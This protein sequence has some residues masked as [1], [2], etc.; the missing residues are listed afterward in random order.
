M[1]DNINP[2]SKISVVAY[3]DACLSTRAENVVDFD[4]EQ[5]LDLVDRLVKKMS[6]FDHCVGLAANQ[7]GSNLNVFV[8]DASKNKRE[9]SKYGFS[10]V[11]NAAIVER[12]GEIK[13]R[14]GCMSVTDLTVDVTRSEKIRVE[15]QDG[16]GSEISFELE[17]F[18]ARV[19]QHEIDH[20]HGKV[21]LDRARSTRDI[22]IRKHYTK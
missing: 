22:Y 2:I 19:F 17:G 7:I 9:V 4:D 20:L 3:P 14:E 11:V 8:A 5:Y 6:E 18:E 10:V 16:S 1:S 12:S 15:G 13:K 21:I